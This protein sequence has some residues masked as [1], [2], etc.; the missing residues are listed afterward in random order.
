MSARLDSIYASIPGWV[1]LQI[2][3]G[4]SLN[5][6]ALQIQ[7][8]KLRDHAPVHIQISRER[9]IPKQEQPRAHE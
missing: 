7:A 2:N 1:L 5:A 6:S 8:D 4:C 3:G 9:R